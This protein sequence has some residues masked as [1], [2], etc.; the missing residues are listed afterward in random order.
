MASFVLLNEIKTIIGFGNLVPKRPSFPAPPTFKGKAL[1]TRLW[2]RFY[3]NLSKIMKVSVRVISLSLRLRLITPTSTLIILDITKTSSNN[4]LIMCRYF[5]CF[6]VPS[7]RSREN[8]TGTQSSAHTV[9]PSVKQKINS[10]AT[11]KSRQLCKT[12]LYQET[13]LTDR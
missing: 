10:V 13:H 3:P 9:N 11:V 7:P 1:G 4:C 2:I 5:A 6:T 8:V 12:S